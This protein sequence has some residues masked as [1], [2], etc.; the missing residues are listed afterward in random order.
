LI[1]RYKTSVPARRA[2]IPAHLRVP[3][4]SLPKALVQAIFFTTEGS[5]KSL[6]AMAIG[7]V[8]TLVSGVAFAQNGNMMNGGGM[9]SGSWA[10]GYGGYWMPILLIA[11][12]GVVVWAVL[13]RLK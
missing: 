13:K 10:S 6:T 4:V 2:E 8:S 11:V 9:W 7:S 12:V 1:L 3:G 5:M